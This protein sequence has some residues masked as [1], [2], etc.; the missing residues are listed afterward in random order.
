MVIPGGDIHR[1][2]VIAIDE[3]VEFSGGCGL[4]VI[5]RLSQEKGDLLALM[6]FLQIEDWLGVETHAGEGLWNNKK[7]LTEGRFLGSSCPRKEPSY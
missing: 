2:H 7:S 3:R 1:I 5:R 4:E 6:E